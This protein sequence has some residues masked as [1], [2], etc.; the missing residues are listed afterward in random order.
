MTCRS[1][2]A[3]DFSLGIPEVLIVEVVEGTVAISGQIHDLGGAPV[4]HLFVLGSIV[5][6]IGDSVSIGAVAG[7][8]SC[9]EPCDF[10][11][12]APYPAPVAYLFPITSSVLPLTVPF[13]FGTDT[14]ATNE[15][16]ATAT[17]R[18]SLSGVARATYVYEPAAI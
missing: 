10:L 4:V 3:F 17:I 11:F 1:I 2:P 15:L 8:K 7:F 13:A 18:T 5:D 14:F 12:E 16:S 9:T 6:L